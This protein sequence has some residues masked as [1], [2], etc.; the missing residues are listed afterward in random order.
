MTAAVLSVIGFLI[1]LKG[2]NLQRKA[3][4]K[5]EKEY[6]MLVCGGA[7]IVTATA[8]LMR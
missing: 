3:Q 8:F 5:E 7:L 1:A 2:S 4:T 6:S